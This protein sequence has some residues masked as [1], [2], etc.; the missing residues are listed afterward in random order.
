MQHPDPDDLALLA[1]GESLGSA[2]DAHVADCAGLQP[3]DRRLP[4]DGRSGRAEQLRRGRAARRA[5]TSGRR[6]PPNSVS[7]TPGAS[8]VAHPRSARADPGHGWCRQPP[9]RSVRIPARSRRQRRTA[10]HAAPSTRN[11][12]APPHL[13]SVPPTP[14]GPALTPDVASADQA[15]GADL[16]PAAPTSGG[17]AGGGT[18]PARWSR[19]VAPLAAAVVGIAIGAGAV[20]LAQ[21]RSD[22]VTVEAIAPLTPVADGPLGTDTGT[23]RRGRVGRRRNRPAGPG[24]RRPTCRRRRTPTRSGC[25]VTTGG[26]SRS[27]PSTTAP[28]RSPCRRASTP[29]S[30]GWSTSPTS[31]RTATRRTPGSA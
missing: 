24:Q 3:R 20:V 10:P 25:S 1:L 4:H 26:W 30:T 2:V 6:S 28:D 14:A 7:P 22:D 13:R 16:P 9:T 27:A 17:A 21:N 15:A 5:S 18:P 8:S 19:W 23:A 12:S 31:R 11:G 29:G